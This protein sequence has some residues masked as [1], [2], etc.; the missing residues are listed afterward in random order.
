M[1]RRPTTEF[2]KIRRYDVDDGLRIISKPFRNQG[3]LDREFGD[4]RIV[5]G[6]RMESD[7][8]LDGGD[9]FSNGLV[10]GAIGGLRPFKI[11]SNQ[12]EE[13]FFVD[14]Q[15]F[16]IGIPAFELFQ[17]RQRGREK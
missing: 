12:L 16:P 1:L 17:I 15:V 11:F 9:A 5:S 10:Y 2:F 14:L 4:F 6:M 3:A 8:A 7:F 13:G